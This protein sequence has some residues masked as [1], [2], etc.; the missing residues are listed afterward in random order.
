MSNGAE[1]IE[2]KVMR[3]NPSVD[4]EPRYDVYRIPYVEG[5]S[6]SNVLEFICEEYD[7]GLAHYLS[8]RRGVCSGC[9]VRV[10]GKPVLACTEI[11][12]G[13]MT[14]EPVNRNRIVKDLVVRSSTRTKEVV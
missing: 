9:M 10:D 1:S 13:D 6:V 8:C 7:G 12:K 4:Q 11:V 2:V 5:C 3:F 14:I